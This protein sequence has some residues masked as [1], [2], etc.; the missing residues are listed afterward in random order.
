MTRVQVVHTGGLRQEAHARQHTMVLDEP[1]D[2]GGDDDGMN[3]YEALLAALGGCIG[4]TLRLYATRKGWNLAGVRVTLAHER[5]HA[6]DCRDCEHKEG[7]ID[8]I[9]R[10]VEIEGDLDASQRA[11]LLDIAGRCPVSRTLTGVIEIKND[12][13]LA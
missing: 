10:K 11:R 8:V 13:A 7:M 9:R 6:D 12:D 4:M 3:P 1:R 5:V 2:A